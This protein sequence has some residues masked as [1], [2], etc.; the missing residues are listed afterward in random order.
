MA[1]E[2]NMKVQAAIRDAL[3]RIAS[4]KPEGWMLP[5]LHPDELAAA[6]NGAIEAIH[7]Q[8]IAEA[9]ESR[10]PRLE[11]RYHEGDAKVYEVGRWNVHVHPDGTVTQEDRGHRWDRTGDPRRAFPN[12][13]VV[14]GELRL[15]VADLVG[16][17]LRRTE[18]A[19]L[20]RALWGNQDVREAFLDEMA[21]SYRSQSEVTEAERREWLHKVRASVHSLTLDRAC[22]K[23]FQAEYEHARY[24]DRFTMT[25][26]LNRRLEAAGSAIRMECEPEHPDFRIGGNAW[27]EARDYWRRMMVGRFSP[28]AEPMQD[29]IGGVAGLGSEP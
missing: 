14:D 23:L 10:L 24:F 29:H 17:I 13:E 8:P 21:M 20:A 28:P 16:E 4:T 26:N 27:N 9:W 22:Q 2:L 3:E 18:P 1:D 19:E 5:P 25:T 6:A 15:P 11:P 7:G 12:M